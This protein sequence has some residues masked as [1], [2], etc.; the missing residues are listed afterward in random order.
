MVFRSARSG[1]MLLL[2]TMSILLSES[3]S[4]SECEKGAY[5]FGA[6]HICVGD[7]YI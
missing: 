5:D 6:S 7:P 2:L 3:S 1:L 4:G